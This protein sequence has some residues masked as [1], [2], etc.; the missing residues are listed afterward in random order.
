MNI[1]PLRDVQACYR[2]PRAALYFHKFSTII[3]VKI[4]VDRDDVRIGT[5]SPGF[6]VKYIS[7]R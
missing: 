6:S 4:V 2:A 7:S 3:V 5:P 1:K